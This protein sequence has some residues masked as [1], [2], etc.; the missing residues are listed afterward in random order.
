MEMDTE[1]EML[2]RGN[3]KEKS[4]LNDSKGFIAITFD[5]MDSKAFR[6]LTESGLKALIFCM[7]KVKIKNPIDRFKYQF[8][9]TYPEANKQ[10]ICDASFCRGIKQLQGLGFIDIVIK[11]GR[12]GESKF[13]THY[14]LSQR[15]KKYN[16]PEFKNHWE[17]HCV[18]IH[19]DD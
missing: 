15:W 14:R 13:C 7:R 18:D 9:F 2:R 5:M 12:R 11:G 10:G 16:T 17:G 8:L 19:G 1:R 6:K 4:W 3:R